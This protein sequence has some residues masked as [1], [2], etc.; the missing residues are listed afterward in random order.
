MNNENVNLNTEKLLEEYRPNNTKRVK[1][2]III[3]IPLLLICV[4][5]LVTLV[6]V[7]IPSQ[8][9]KEAKKMYNS[10][11]YELAYLAYREAGNY[12]DSETKAEEI[13]RQYP[14]V[15]RIGDY[16]ILGSYE[17]DN[18]MENGKE[19]IEWQVLEKEGT[20]FFVVSRYALDVKP[21]HSTE[22]PITWADCSLR[23]WL[24]NDFLNS[25]FNST[26]QDKI[27]WTQVKNNDNMEYKT[28][29]GRDTEDRV[30]LLSLD[31]VNRYFS[32]EKE[33]QCIVTTYANEDHVSGEGCF[34]W[35]RTSGFKPVG[36]YEDFCDSDCAVNI[37]PHG[38][39]DEMGCPV[40]DTDGN[41]VRPAM[42][43]DLE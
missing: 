8:K 30:F 1:R 33:R 12:K 26:E 31:E 5:F 14:T 16:M 20:R 29:G 2:T 32:E 41:Y 17:Q 18:N 27:L 37:F 13:L 25:A 22:E 36:V 35:L 43:I 23:Q 6:T 9:Y 28:N 10:N 42:W 11:E 40:E 21:Y 7:V 15:A 34:W 39:I 38:K 3:L 4:A 19:D 24:N